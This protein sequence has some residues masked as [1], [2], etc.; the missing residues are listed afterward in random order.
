MKKK[1]REKFHN[2]DNFQF[3][4]FIIMPLKKFFHSIFWKILKIYFRTWN[5]LCD[6]EK[7]RQGAVI[8]T[9]FFWG[10]CTTI[11]ISSFADLQKNQ[12]L[13][14]LVSRGT[15]PTKVG[16]EVV[17]ISA[18]QLDFSTWKVHLKL[19][20]FQKLRKTFFWFFKMELPTYLLFSIY[21]SYTS[22]STV[23]QFWKKLNLLG[24]I[25]AEQF[26]FEIY[27]F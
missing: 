3:N 6:F 25:I 11:V 14:H 17:K 2:N 9:T 15:Q 18:L 27:D 7:L 22:A 16:R 24:S 4:I 26:T 21:V 13:L 5:K 19:T 8:L 10:H 20:N 23:L 12:N 1:K